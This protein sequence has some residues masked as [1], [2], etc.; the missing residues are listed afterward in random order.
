MRKSIAWFVKRSS[1]S[2]KAA[3]G[4]T[5]QKLVVALVAV[6]FAV[7]SGNI[8]NC[9]DLPEFYGVYVKTSSGMIKELIKNDK[10]YSTG[11][12]VGNDLG[13]ALEASMNTKSFIT[14]FSAVTLAASDVKG[15]IVY[16]EIDINKVTIN[17]LSNK[18]VPEGA[19][20][21]EYRGP[22]PANRQSMFF[23]SDPLEVRSKPLKDKMYYMQPKEAF[24]P[25]CYAVTIGS[26][27]YDFEIKNTTDKSPLIGKWT[28]KFL[29]KEKKLLGGDTYYNRIDLQIDSISSDGS[30]SGLYKQ[31]NAKMEVIDE[32][33]VT[34]FSINQSSGKVYVKGEDKGKEGQL[35]GDQEGDL[36][37]TTGQKCQPGLAIIKLSFKPFDKY[38]NHDFL[39]KYEISWVYEKDI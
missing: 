32:G 33:P 21:A 18:I 16:N 38:K 30:I 28:G 13:A 8:A 11:W 19:R 2:A 27:I 23:L 35:Y 15:L 4:H 26:S 29:K 31:Y 37:M 34:G 25:G 22:Q 17:K 20:F 12:F 39:K 24:T 6:M 1:L 36:S 10:V 7:F 5:K 9:E 14:A 3:K